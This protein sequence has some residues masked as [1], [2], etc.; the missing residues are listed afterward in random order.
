MLHITDL[1]PWKFLEKEKFLTLLLQLFP[2]DTG[3]YFVP[4]Y[5]T[6]YGLKPFSQSFQLFV[7]LCFLQ[8]WPE[9]VSTFLRMAQGNCSA[10]SFANV[11]NKKPFPSGQYLYQVYIISPTLAFP[12]DLLTCIKCTHYLAFD[13]CYQRP[14]P[15]RLET[16]H[17]YLLC[18]INF[19]ATRKAQWFT[20]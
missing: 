14:E 16:C 6:L 17:W 2:N 5:P 9:N 1:C 18:N 10:E 12:L 4:V 13:L 15:N 3:R 20:C 11:C 7:S 8:T 19:A